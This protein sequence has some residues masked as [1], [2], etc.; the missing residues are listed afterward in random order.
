MGGTDRCSAGPP[1][2]A[3]GWPCPSKG[4]RSPPLISFREIALKFTSFTFA[5]LDAG[6]RLCAVGI[7]VGRLYTPARGPCP[8][9][10]ASLPPPAA[11]FL[12]D[13]KTIR[14][15][16]VWWWP[17]GPLAPRNPGRGLAVLMLEE[18]GMREQQ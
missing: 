15:R 12:P 11:H 2:S 13:R 16:R 10:W 7:R 18:Q 3:L 9:R 14:A 1:V 17:P 8:R 6:R 4:P 5:S